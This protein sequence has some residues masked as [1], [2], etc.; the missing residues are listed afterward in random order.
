MAAWKKGQGRNLT[1]P[2]HEL[3]DNTNHD[4]VVDHREDLKIRVQIAI[5]TSALEMSWNPERERCIQ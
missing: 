3:E 1:R 4:V 2:S 5:G